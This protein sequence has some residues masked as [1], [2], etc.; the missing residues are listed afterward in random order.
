M[1]FKYFSIIILSFMIL[2]PYNTIYNQDLASPQNSKTKLNLASKKIPLLNLT[3]SIFEELQETVWIT[4]DIKSN[5]DLYVIF[6]DNQY[7]RV[8]VTRGAVAKYPTES[9]PIKFIQEGP[10]PNSGIFVIPSQKKILYYS[11]YF[12]NQYYLLISPGYNQI[13]PLLK[14]TIPEYFK[15]GYILQLVY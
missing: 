12:L 15:D 13:E 6:N 2:L 9:Y 3:T 1:T 11:F 4:S 14:L 10:Y 8:S 5:K 7:G